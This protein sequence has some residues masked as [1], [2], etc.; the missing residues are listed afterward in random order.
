MPNFIEIK[1]PFVA[2][3]RD[4]HMGPALLGRLLVDLQSIICVRFL[5]EIIY[6]H[7]S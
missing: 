7:I 6:H 5:L 3:Q 1:E 4:R 2:E